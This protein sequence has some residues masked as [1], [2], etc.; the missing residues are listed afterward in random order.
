MKITQAEKNLFNNLAIS[1]LKHITLKTD[2]SHLGAT[3][4]QLRW[5]QYCAI[6]GKD[7][8]QY[9]KI[10]AALLMNEAE[11][12]TLPT[13]ELGEF[14]YD[15]ECNRKPVEW[16]VL[17][18]LV[19]D[20]DDPNKDQYQILL[21]KNGLCSNRIFRTENQLIYDI[22]KETDDDVHIHTFGNLPLLWLD[23]VFRTTY[24]RCCTPTPF[25]VKTGVKQDKNGFCN[26]F[27]G[28]D[29]EVDAQGLLQTSDDSFTTA[30]RPMIVL[31]KDHLTNVRRINQIQSK[32]P[33]L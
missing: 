18:D 20:E 28:S 10:I 13:I 6:K 5:E 33:V 12:E 11:V 9:K 1:I 4:A 24:D 21:S 3:R 19:L 22:F 7:P 30:V 16:Y 8:V 23:R 2:K 25:A 17:N 14:Y 26:W 29:M 32:T 15:E 27:I 31:R